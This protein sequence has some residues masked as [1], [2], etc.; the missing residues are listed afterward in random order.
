[1]LMSFRAFK[2]SRLALQM[3]LSLTLISPLSSVL[4]LVLWM[5]TLLVVR[6]LDKSLP[7]ISPPVA[8]MVKSVGSMSQIPV[9][10]VSDE[11]DTLVPCSILTVAALVSINPPSWPFLPSAVSVPLT[12]TSPCCISPN[13][14]IS[15]LA[16]CTNRLAAMIPL[17]LTTALLKLSLAWAVKYTAPLFATIAPPL[18]TKPC[19]TPS[20]TWYWVKLPSCS[21]KVTWLAAVKWVV[22]L[23]VLIEPVLITVGAM[24]ATVPPDKVL[25]DPWFSILA[26][27]LASPF[28]RY[29][30]V[31][32]SLSLS[33]RVEATIPPT[34]TCA[35]L[36]NTTPLGLSKNTWPLAF[37]RPMIWEALL[38]S[39]W[40]M[41]TEDW[42]GWLKLTVASWPM[43][44]VFQLLL[45]VWLFW[46][47]LSVSLVWVKLA[48]P[49]FTWAPVGNALF[50]MAAWTD[51][52]SMAMP[53]NSAA[54]SVWD[55]V[56]VARLDTPLVWLR[57]PWP[58]ANSDTA[59]QQLRREF[60]ITL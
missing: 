31:W 24:S 35:V 29:L 12:T 32:I 48:E 40:L 6:L 49:E 23:G 30:P 60:H 33:C 11:V 37:S 44:K 59:C 38:S 18:S 17:W 5:V 45:R 46:L 25:I 3:T 42:L 55:K 51:R 28:N 26:L 36:E 2:V 22:P 53:N 21:A 8:A 47:M 52:G 58:L 4:P 14:M 1:M 39:T 41:A 43:L 13:K 54:E 10:A 20:S 19:S 56:A 34:F 50:W 9:C 27:L 7:V 57:E 16:F 15:P